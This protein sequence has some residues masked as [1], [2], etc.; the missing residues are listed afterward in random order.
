MSEKQTVYLPRIETRIGVAGYKGSN[1]KYIDQRPA[2]A[3]SDVSGPVAKKTP[4]ARPTPPAV[5]RAKAARA[6]SR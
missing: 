1:V 4:K 3:S 6:S 5:R 2:E